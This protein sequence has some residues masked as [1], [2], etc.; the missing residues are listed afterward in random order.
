MLFKEK[1]TASSA[2]FS[3][4]QDS[5][6]VTVVS[7]HR[8]FPKCTVKNANSQQPRGQFISSLIFFLILSNMF[9][10][11]RSNY[12]GWLIL[13]YCWHIKVGNNYWRT[14]LQDILEQWWVGSKTKRKISQPH[15]RRLVM[16]DTLT[17]TRLLPQNYIS[18]SSQHQA[19]NSILNQW[20]SLS[21]TGSW[22][23]Y[24]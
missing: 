15:D 18:E 11:T 9:Y 20:S 24:G 21:Y 16:W 7:N 5:A 10:F 6:G 19:P 8:S 1:H 4:N 12:F 22:M 3:K 2:F 13:I 17:I 23:A 14:Y